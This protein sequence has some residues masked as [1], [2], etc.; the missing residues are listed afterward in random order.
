MRC[1]ISSGYKLQLFGIDIFNF[2]IVQQRRNRV[3]EV[4]D[5]YRI[6]IALSTDIWQGTRS[7][8]T[9]TYDG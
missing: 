9:V 8:A 5:F 7:S 1:L 3:L 4:E 6:K 2:T